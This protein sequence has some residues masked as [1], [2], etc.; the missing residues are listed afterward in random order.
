MAT[1]IGADEELD[2]KYGIDPSAGGSFYRLF[3]EGNQ[4]PIAKEETDE[5]SEMSI[6][7]L[8]LHCSEMKLFLGILD[9]Q[10][11]SLCSPRRLCH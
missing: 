10:Y 5:F 6:V 4:K 7:R 8:S 3:V 1:T 2:K 11:N 9:F